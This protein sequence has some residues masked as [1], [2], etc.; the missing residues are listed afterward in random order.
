[1]TS[2]PISLLRFNRWLLFA[3]LGLLQLALWLGTDSIWS[4]PFLFAHLGLFLLWQPLWRGESELRPGSIAFILCASIAGLW[5][6][7]WWLL[8]L[9]VSG[10]FS[11]V[12]G[13]VF[14][15]RENRVRLLYLSVMAYLLMAL[16]LMVVPHLFAPLSISDTALDPM[17]AVLP[18][19]L[20]VLLFFPGETG[21]AE[22]KLTEFRR[23]V[24]FI[25]SLLLFLLLMLLVLGSL[26]FMMLAHVDYA[27]AL[28]RTMFSMALVL[29]ALGW[30][31]NPRFGFTGLQPLFSRYLLNV[32]SPFESWLSQLA[33]TA[34]H[35]QNPDAFLARAAEHLAALPWLTGVSWQAGESSGSLGK[36]SPNFI[37]VTEGGLRLTFFSQQII[38]PAVLLHIHLLTRLLAH[39][40]QAKQHEQHIRDMA[41]LQ[42]IYETGARMTH[43]L[44]N[45]LQS[46]FALTSLAQQNKET[47]IPALQEQLPVLAQ[48]IESA[49]SKLKL[50]QIE[51]EAAM[52]PLAAWWESLRLRHQ[53]AGLIWLSG[54]GLSSSTSAIPIALFDSAA[55][56]LIDNACAKRLQQPGM[57]IRITLRTGPV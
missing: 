45:M 51:N 56:N 20:A 28:L 12:G 47:A 43:D 34:Q 16:F 52:Q 49:L 7:S 36:T 54:D 30:L 31:W 32:G 15:S 13:R 17:K 41:R 3:M 39:F 44:K 23:T 46:L 35:E 8:A 25:Y 48:R 19:L 10:L 21:S 1:M 42:A 11:L 14:F 33:E 18:L 9:W 57:S 27:G 4:R 37:D 26:S 2:L 38:G 6:L 5:W 55:D 40:Y 22:G 50:P 29:F 53:Y 24:D